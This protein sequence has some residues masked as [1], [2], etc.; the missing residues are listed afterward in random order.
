M[1]SSIYADENYKGYINRIH[2]KSHNIWEK[3]EKQMT[4]II[5]TMRKDH[6]WILNKNLRFINFFKIWK[7]LKISKTG[8]GLLEKTVIMC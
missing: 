4:E 5:V 6:N 3:N 1:N 7:M 2:E 8:V